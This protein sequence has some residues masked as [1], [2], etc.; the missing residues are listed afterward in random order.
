LATLVLIPC[1][2]S[3]F[4][5][6]S[7]AST[8]RIADMAK[9]PSAVVLNQ[10]PARGSVADEAEADLKDRAKVCPVRLGARVAYSYAT[11][12]GRSV[13]EYEPGGQAAQEVE[14]LY[15]WTMKQPAN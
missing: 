3:K 5:L 2:P 8:L 9:V 1:R 6:R 4:D 7:V 14:A 15:R 10:V 12:D 11:F 13:F